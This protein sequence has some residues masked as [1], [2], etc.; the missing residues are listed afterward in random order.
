MTKELPKYLKE[1]SGFCYVATE[2]LLKVKRLTPWNGEI[3]KH[4]MAIEDDA[5]PARQP[6]PA[7]PKA[8]KADE[9]QAADT[10]ATETSVVETPAS[11]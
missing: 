4:G 3:D 6:K 8:A 9:A 10:P 5:K 11:E 7:K 2:Q 1:E